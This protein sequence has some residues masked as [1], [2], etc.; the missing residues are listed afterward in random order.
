ML[1]FMSSVFFL[2]S[3]NAPRCKFDIMAAMKLDADK[4]YQVWPI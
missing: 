3:A 2:L 1:M 4:E